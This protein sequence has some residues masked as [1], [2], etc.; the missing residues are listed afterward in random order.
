MIGIFD[1]GFGWLQSLSYIRSLYP[2]YDYIFLADRKNFPYG[3]KTPEEI[4]Q[5]TFAA[6]HRL[7]DQWAKLVIVACNTASAYAIRPWQ[8]QF[9]DKK[10]LSVTIPGVER[11]VESCHNH[12]GV[13]ATQAT[14]MS[15][16]YNELFTKLGGQSDA[17]LQLIMAPELI[18]IVESGEY[19]SDKSKKLVKEYLGKFNKK[20]ECLVLWCTHFPALI[21][22]IREEYTGTIIDPAWESAQTLWPYLTKHEEISGK[23]W[24]HGSLKLYTTGRVE[25]FLEVGKN[26]LPTIEGVEHVDL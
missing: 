9:P 21:P 16:V 2:Q 20:M 15:G 17:D 3:N 23:L 10:A 19:A 24:R 8:S 22:L 4:E 1:S 7:F 14:V 5:H 25:T 6:L 11:L 13:L 18:D 12:I 26:F